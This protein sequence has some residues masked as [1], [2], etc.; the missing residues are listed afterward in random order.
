VS[1]TRRASQ[2]HAWLPRWCRLRLDSRQLV[3]HSTYLRIHL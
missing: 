1:A 2:R 3:K